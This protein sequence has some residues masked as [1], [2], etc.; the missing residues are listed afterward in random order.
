MKPIV[1]ATLI[2]ALS[3]LIVLESVRADPGTPSQQYLAILK[4]YNP[5]SGGLRKATTDLERKAAVELLA[6]FAPKS[7]GRRSVGGCHRRR[8]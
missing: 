6:T 1:V 7:Q 3:L 4:E 8:L 5:A 2:F